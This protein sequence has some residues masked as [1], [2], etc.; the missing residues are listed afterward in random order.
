MDAQLKDHLLQLAQTRCLPKAHEEY[1]WSLK[2]N[3]FEPKVV[4]DIGSCALHWTSIAKTVWPNAEF[5]LFDAF[6]KVEMLYQGYKYHIGVLSNSDN[7]MVK[8]YQNDYLPTGNSYYRE[9]ATNVFPTESFRL[10]QTSTL[11]SVV[12]TK[13]FPSPDL[14]KIDVQ[15]AELDVLAGATNTLKTAKH[16]IVELQHKRYNEGAPMVSES[17]PHIESLGF[18]C[19]APLFCSNGEFDGDYGFERK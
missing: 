3:G 14:I 9:V 6:D 5:I 15:G 4:Y 13:D 8:F 11:D 7:T 17:L 18:K 19:V 10:L 2:R 1:L 16:L 12:S